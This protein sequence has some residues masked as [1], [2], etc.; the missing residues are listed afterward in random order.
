[1][2]TV[3]AAIV[4]ITIYGTCVVN[5]NT[6]GRLGEPTTELGSRAG[7]FLIG[8][9]SG[10]RDSG[11]VDAAASCTTCG[12]TYQSQVNLVTASELEPGP[13]DDFPPRD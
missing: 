8:F 13:S 1:M 7:S 2:K 5:Q 4:A 10:N 3:W 12:I 6:R 9:L 11:A